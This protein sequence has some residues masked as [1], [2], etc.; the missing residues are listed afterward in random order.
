L[1]VNSKTYQVIYI[2]KVIKTLEELQAILLSA[3]KGN[4]LVEVEKRGNAY[5][6]PLEAIAAICGDSSGQIKEPNDSSGYRNV[7]VKNTLNDEVQ[8]SK[9]TPSDN[10]DAKVTLTALEIWEIV[11][12]QCIFVMSATAATRTVKMGMDFL[13]GTLDHANATRSF[14]TSVL[15]LT[16]SQHGQIFMSRNGV[17]GTNTN[18]TYVT[19][20][21]ENPLSTEL[22][23][24]STIESIIA[25]NKQTG[26]RSELTVL[27][28]KKKAA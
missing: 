13:G 17:Y 15:T 24:T 4:V 14:E 9:D 6:L 2:S 28:Q 22:Y 11:A 27:Y 12:I 25:T 10:T 23:G 19:V 8:R 18:G 26:D 3:A 20:V 21:D 5:I 1:S 7:V 16:A